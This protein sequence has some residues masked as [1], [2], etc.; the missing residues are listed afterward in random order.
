MEKL[1]KGCKIQVLDSGLWRDATI[2]EIQCEKYFV[3]FDNFTTK[4]NTLVDSDVIRQP[5]EKRAI[6]RNTLRVKSNTLE[7]MVI[8]DQIIY[9]KNDSE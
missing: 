9:E 3:Q 1:T 4:H 2:L 7:T 8:K 5:R 6:Q